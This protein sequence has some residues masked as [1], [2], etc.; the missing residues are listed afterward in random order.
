M[1]IWMD[2]L[3]LLA[4]A[5]GETG[6]AAWPLK[7]FIFIVVGVFVVGFAI[8]HYFAEKKRAGELEEWAG[9]N[10]F[11][12]ESGRNYELARDFQAMKRLRHGGNRYAFNVMR[13]N[14]QGQ[15]V[16]LFDYHYETQENDGQG[17]T[18]TQHHYFN[19]ASL[20]LPRPFPGIQI[21]PVNIINKLESM[22]GFE[23][24]TFES[25]E[26]SRKYR[27]TSPDKKYAYDFCNAQMIQYLTDLTPPTMVEQED[28]ILAVLHHGETQPAS[29]PVHLK[30]LADVRGL[31]PNYLFE[32]EGPLVPDGQSPAAG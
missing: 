31:L 14:Y 10:G 26:F 29:V 25:A 6:G 19:V 27:V 5:S 28:E 15:P 23:G 22:V 21:A 1:H 2:G 16:L 8:Y 12:F 17:G 32:A 20:T 24:I 3:S 9:Q 13:G 7:I 11:T 4:Q 18:R 30:R